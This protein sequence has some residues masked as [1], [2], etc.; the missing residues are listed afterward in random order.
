MSTDQD[1]ITKKIAALLALLASSFTVPEL[2]RMVAAREIGPLNARIDSIYEALAEVSLAAFLALLP[3]ASQGIGLVANST[4]WRIARDQAHVR[5]SV[6]TVLAADQRELVRSIA[7]AAGT[8]SPKLTAV[9]LR[10][11]LGLTSA[12]HARVV[13]YE[14]VALTPTRRES[15]EGDLVSI[16]QLAVMTAARARQLR[17][18]RAIALGLVE[19]QRSRG[20]AY[21]EAW[22]QA[23]DAKIVSPHDVVRT[24][25]VAG[26]NTRDSHAA[27]DQAKVGLDEPFTSGLGNQL[28]YPCDGAAPPA[29]VAGCQC[30][31]TYARR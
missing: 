5:Q 11:A 19:W 6:S 21:L 15:D 13:Q 16:D 24:W 29:D 7:L 1:E 2:E 3:E 10:N 18:D 22:H 4:T 27:M 25:N 30:W 17:A 14:R 9:R 20:R 23:V 12:Q 8:A 28:M 26:H 31:V